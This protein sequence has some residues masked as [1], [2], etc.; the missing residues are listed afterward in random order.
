MARQRFTKK[1]FIVAVAAK[2]G[3]T[4]AMAQ[5]A[6]TAV[7]AAIVQAVRDG[8]TVRIDGLGLF[9]PVLR[10]QRSHFNPHTGARDVVPAK[11]A[12]TFKAQSGLFD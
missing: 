8:V 9:K 11:Q 2:Y 7:S 5:E 6:I 3:W 12:L 4:Q 1:Q 10:A